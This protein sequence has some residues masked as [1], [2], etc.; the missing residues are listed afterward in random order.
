M[1]D[2]YQDVETDTRAAVEAALEALLS[3]HQAGLHSALSSALDTRAGFEQLGRKPSAS[4][5]LPDDTKA[6]AN[7]FRRVDRCV[8]TW[9]VQKDARRARSYGEADRFRVSARSTAWSPVSRG[10]MRTT[11]PRPQPNRLQRHRAQPVR[12]TPAH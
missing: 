3:G 9:I 2:H 6:A 5:A 7:V 12:N 1:S 4:W 10:Y 8:G 11:A